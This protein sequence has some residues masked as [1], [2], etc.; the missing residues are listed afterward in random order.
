MFVISGG[1]V[2]DLGKIDGINQWPALTESKTFKRTTLL[3]NIDEIYNS[4]AIIG[5]DGRY[6]LVNGNN[7]RLQKHHTLKLYPYRFY[8]LFRDR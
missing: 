6:K 7:N 2:K 3:L 4:S 8:D 5:E 1:N